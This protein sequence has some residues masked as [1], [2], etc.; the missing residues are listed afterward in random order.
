MGKITK[1]AKSDLS[2]IKIGTL[3]RFN[4]IHLLTVHWYPP[5]E[6]SC[7]H[8]EKVTEQFLNKWSKW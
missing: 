7:I 3:E 1:N 6:A 2:D 8:R 4:H 5:W